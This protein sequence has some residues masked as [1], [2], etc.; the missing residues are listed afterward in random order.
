[1]N[2]RPVDR[3][4]SLLNQVR[5]VGP[6]KWM[7]RS[8]A[9]PDQRTGSLSIR[10][11][12]DGRVLIKDFAGTATQEVLALLGLSFGDLYPD[13]LP[14]TSSG[15]ARDWRHAHAARDALLLIDREAR[16]VCVA[17]ENLAHGVALDHSD[18]DRLLLASQ[19]ITRAREAV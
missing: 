14:T 17:A 4:L 18:R 2:A 1:M 7:A 8:P 19:R 15:A 16:L 12:E 3:L 13:P 6:G 11:L 5:E 9:F 10:E